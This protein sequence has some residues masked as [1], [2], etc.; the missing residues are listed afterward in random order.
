MA[1]GKNKTGRDYPK[2]LGARI[3]QARLGKGLKLVQVAK[4]AGL[5]PS[6]ISQI[7]TSKITPT[8]VTLKKIAAALDQPLG[9]FFNAPFP[10]MASAA[11]GTAP[12]SPVVH[13]GQRKLLSPGKGVTFQL[14]NPDLSGPIEFIY[15]LYEPG[16]GT[17]AE[18]YSHPGSECGLIL[19]GELLITIRDKS[20][21]LKEGDSITFNSS[22]PHAK[23]NPGKT[24]CVCVWANH[25]PWF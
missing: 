16:A 5:T 9:D 17:G 18:Q 24:R 2:N 25:P 23:Q 19:E 1:A 13:R 11:P 14:L 7:E 12:A 4:R 8:I 22:E 15:N 3:R 20:Y 6:S 21:L 10:E